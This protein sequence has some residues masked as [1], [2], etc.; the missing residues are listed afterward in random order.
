MIKSM[1]ANSDKVKADDKVLER[2]QIVRMEGYGWKT[3]SG[4]TGGKVTGS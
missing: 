4:K 2:W 1:T 3:V